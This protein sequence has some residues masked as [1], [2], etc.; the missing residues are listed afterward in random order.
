VTVRPGRD[1]AMARMGGYG[2][3]SLSV[4]ASRL[5]PTS[6]MVGV[7][8]DSTAGYRMNSAY[9]G[10]TAI[11]KIAFSPT[12][13]GMVHYYQQEL[14]VPG[15]LT[16]PTPNDHQSFRRTVLQLEWGPEDRSALTGRINYRSEGLTFT[17]PVNGTSV[18]NSSVTGL[19]AQR[20]LPLGAGQLLIG[21]IELQR[22]S[23]SANVSGSP[24][25]QDITV[26]AAYL[27]YDAAVTPRLLASVGW[28]I[29]TLAPYGS[30]LDPRAGIVYLMTDATRLRASVGRTFRAPTFLDLYFPGFGNPNLRP[31]HAW[32]AEL[33][34]EHQ[35][36]GLTY[37]ATAFGTD[38]T[39][40]ITFV[41][42]PVF[43]A[44]NI[45]SAS[46]RGISA[47][48][49]GTFAPRWTG[50]TNVT[51]L[52]AIDQTT[53]ASLR[54]VPSVTANLVLHYQLTPSSTVS[55]IVNYVG[56]QPDP[57]G[58]LPSYVDLQLRYQVTMPDGWSWIVGVN[59]ALDQSYQVVS[60]FPAPG[61]TVFVNVTKSF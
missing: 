25:V 14:G 35:S 45:G 55:L 10:Q 7:T 16:F 36:G 33:G 50:A 6:W 5:G 28:R 53:G 24:I 21:G 11:G 19:E 1:Q 2:E 17:S 39:D 60:G 43:Q 46:I 3:H 56:T 23:L 48:V 12:L 8:S 44:V 38:A 29:D 61:R 26:G 40:L 59:N 32:E 20:V 47:E 58:Q 18:Y 4:S 22:Q 37:A 15:S 49:R 9:D 13:R 27:Q 57:P 54:G 34:I 51:V 31:E 41:F 42:T 52:S 30:S